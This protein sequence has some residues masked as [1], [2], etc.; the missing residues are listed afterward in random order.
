ME[1]VSSV[2]GRGGTWRKKAW[3]QPF[4][5]CILIPATQGLLKVGC[6]SVAK[7]IIAKENKPEKFK[8]GGEHLGLV[9]QDWGPQRFLL[10]DPLSH[11]PSG[12]KKE[13]RGPK[14]V[15]PPSLPLP[16]FS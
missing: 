6:F 14:K 15:S 16:A 8:W 2:W 10:C 7:G 11:P 5:M 3:G 12:E 4:E 13:R 1:Q 9:V